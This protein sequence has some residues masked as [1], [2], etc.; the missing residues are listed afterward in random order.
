MTYTEFNKFWDQV[1]EEIE[2]GKRCNKC[3]SRVVKTPDAFGSFRILGLN[4]V[5]N[6]ALCAA[7]GLHTL[8][9]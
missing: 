5:D 7:G 4:A 3:G 9:T 6:I 1:A 8:T 2:A